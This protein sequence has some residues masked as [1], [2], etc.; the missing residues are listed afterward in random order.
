MTDID[1]TTNSTEDLRPES[2]EEAAEIVSQDPGL[3]AASGGDDAQTD[4]DARTPDTAP[5]G[6]T[7][8]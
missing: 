5:V 6:E 7:R 4:D 8:E 3:N 1:P 2:T